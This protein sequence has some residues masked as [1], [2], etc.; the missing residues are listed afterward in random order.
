MTL[1]TALF[2]AVSG[3]IHAIAAVHLLAGHSKRQDVLSQELSAL[4]EAMGPGDEDDEHKFS[5]EPV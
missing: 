5:A 4:I 1:L 2:F 3:A